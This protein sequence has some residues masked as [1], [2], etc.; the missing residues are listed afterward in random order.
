ML[1]MKKY[2]SM[3]AFA[4]LVTGTIS[5]SKDDD[6]NPPNN[7]INFSSTLSGGVEVPAN[8]STATGTATATYNDNTN[9][10]TVTTTYSGMTA[11]AAHI[12]KGA[13]GVS[14]DVVFP[15]TSLTSPMVLTTAAL[16]AQQEADLKANL[17]YINIHS[18]LYAGGEIRG[19]L[20]RQ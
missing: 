13:V 14:G 10:L 5:C 6:D 2:L 1:N 4:A 20:I 9:I 16:T 7:I 12:H 3:L 8:P 17:Y 18:A 15:F 11:T 19:Q